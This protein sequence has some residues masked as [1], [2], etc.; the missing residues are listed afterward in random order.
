MNI[1]DKLLELQEKMLS[2]SADKRIYLEGFLDG[3][4]QN[5]RLATEGG[6]EE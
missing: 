5:E 6:K 3:L 1:M 4:A 2:L